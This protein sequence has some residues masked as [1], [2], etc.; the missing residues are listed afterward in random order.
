[1]NSIV[2]E[3][4]DF[5]EKIKQKYNID[6][7]DT[8]FLT[9]NFSIEKAKG[10]KSISL[11]TNKLTDHDVL[12]ELK[13][14]GLESICLRTAGFDNVDLEYA[15]FLGI[16]VYR[17]AHYSPESIAEYTFSL[18]LALNRKLK[19]EIRKHSNRDNSRTF[20][21]L[22]VVLKGRAL[23]IYGLGKI[24]QAVA[25]IAKGFGMY[26]LFYDTTVQFYNGVEKV[27]SLK[28]LFERSQ[29]ITIHA[30]LTPETR[31]SVNYE[32][33]Q[34]NKYKPFYLINTA[35][36]DIVDSDSIIK[37]LDEGILNGL[38]IDV[39]DSGEIDDIFDER[40]LRD[41]VIQSKHIAFLT[42]ESVKTILEDTRDNLL[43]KP[44]DYNTL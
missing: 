16:N 9:S 41:N 33:L 15:K 17:V 30:P 28:E 26:I 23:G 8:E 40:L 35:R 2:F 44:Q 31:K 10:K 34:L 22:G 25:E 24:G 1:M 42:E 37:S 43:G 18:L 11:F 6:F 20:E 19:I 21:S 39:W 3:W 7:P 14:F 38:G 29:F 13:M 36:G 5:E 4:Q 27:N 32:L 12:N